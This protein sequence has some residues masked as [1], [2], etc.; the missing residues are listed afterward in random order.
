MNDVTAASV[1]GIGIKYLQHVKFIANFSP[2]A[3]EGGSGGGGPPP[4]LPEG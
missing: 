3:A 1:K 2:P 4:C